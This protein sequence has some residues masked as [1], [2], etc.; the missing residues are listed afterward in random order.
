[1]LFERDLG[2]GNRHHDNFLR[3][4][5]LLSYARGDLFVRLE[6]LSRYIACS[7]VTKRP[8]F[9]FVSTA[10]HPGDALVVFPL[11]DDYSFGILQSPVHWAWLTAR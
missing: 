1:M 3:R 9:E 5:W 10:I 4:F 8:I 7:R 6:G 2:K 11:P